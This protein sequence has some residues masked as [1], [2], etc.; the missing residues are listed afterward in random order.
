MRNFLRQFLFFLFCLIPPPLIAQ[1][2]P[3]CTQWMFVRSFL[4]P[5]ATALNKGMDLALWGREQWWGLPGRPS[6]QMLTGGLYVPKA[7]SALGLTVML[8]RLGYQRNLIGRVNYSG[9]ITVNEN[10]FIALGLTVGIVNTATRIQELF[11][12]NPAEPLLQQIPDNKFLPDVGV[13]LEVV[14][15]NWYVGMSGQHLIYGQTSSYPAY[16]RT[17]NLYFS[18]SFDIR[19]SLVRIVPSVLG[20]SPLFSVSVDAN[21]LFYFLK[22]RF[23]LGGGY[24][25]SDGAYGLAGV[26]IV[27]GLFLG[28]SYDYSLSR[29]QTLNTGSHE[30]HLRYM[31]KK[32][33]KPLP[34]FRNVRNY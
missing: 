11:W 20:R 10:I 22:D 21:L 4:N 19:N 16:A 1:N 26:Q 34:F 13:G 32:P 3:N 25:Y 12:Q 2:D 27:K 28:Y 5:A 14:H 18:Y 30:L 23:W 9:Q 33:R 31:Y 24:R 15:P 7:K 6:T 29:L 17:L 8:D